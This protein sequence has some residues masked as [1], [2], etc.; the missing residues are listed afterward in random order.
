MK[1]MLVDDSSTMRRILKNA[2]AKLEI[3]DIVEAVDGKDAI[4]KLT[5]DVSPDVIFLD[6][7]MPN[8]NGLDTLKQIRFMD[9]MKDVKVI[10]CTSESEKTRIIDAIKAGANSY[11][12]K[13]FTPDVLKGKLKEQ[14]FLS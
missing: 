10:M 5:G 11:I 1:V 3:G 6:W 7:N 13:P 12:V 14:G 2:L 9:K 8:M 4:D